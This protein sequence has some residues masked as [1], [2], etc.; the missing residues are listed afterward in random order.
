MV[1]RFVQIVGFNNLARLFEV[2]NF[3]P[4]GVETK[5]ETMSEKLINMVESGT[6]Y[7]AHLTGKYGTVCFIC[8]F[9]GKRV[10]TPLCILPSCL[11]KK[12]I[13]VLVLLS[14]TLSLL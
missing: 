10:I 7:A 5:I 9:L 11:V 1:P 2:A 6:L 4:V 12:Q 8:Y 14:P 3:L 13:P